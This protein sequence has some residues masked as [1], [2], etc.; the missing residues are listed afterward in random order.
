ML[1]QDFVGLPNFYHGKISIMVFTTYF[2]S[3]N[4]EIIAY[5][6]VILQVIYRKLTS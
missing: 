3:Q 6:V 4:K 2:W 1:Y 5:F